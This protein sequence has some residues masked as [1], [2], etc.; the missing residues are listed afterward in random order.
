MQ[1]DERVATSRIDGTEC[2]NGTCI[3]GA[4]MPY[5]GVA[6][7]DKVF[8]LGGLEDSEVESVCTGT[9]VVVCI[10]MPVGAGSRVINTVPFQTVA[11]GL[12]LGV[13]SALEDGEVEGDSGVAT[14]SV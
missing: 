14:C 8:G 13:V 2:V 3:V 12:G 9:V 6:G 7:G 11:D 5:G 10:F 1:D 4:V